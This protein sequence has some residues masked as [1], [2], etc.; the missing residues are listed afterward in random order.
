M[1]AINSVTSTSNALTSSVSALGK[2]DFLL[3]LVTQLQNQDPLNPNDPTEFTAQLAQFSTLEQLFA[4]NS[5]LQ[6]LESGQANMLQMSALSMI[7]KQVA[8]ETGQ[9]TLGAAD[10]RLGY[11]LTGAV[12]QVELVVRNSHDQIVA[13]LEGSNLKAGQ[14]FFSW[15]G[16]D[17]NGKPLAAGDYQLELQAWLGGERV[18]GGAPL[19]RTTVSGVD[20]TG[21]DG[22]LTTAAGAFSMSA[23]ATVSAVSQ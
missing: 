21:L 9:V 10:T 1:T 14:H 23:L 4:V 15:D 6:S 5:Q 2:D 13:V 17:G 16:T 20:L 18:S 19:V 11:Y 8:V 12:D 22:Q 7:G 3:L